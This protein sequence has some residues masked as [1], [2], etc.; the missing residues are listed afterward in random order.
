VVRQLTNSDGYSATDG[1]AL[2][3]E[4]LR[5]A[6]ANG[7]DIWLGAEIV[8][9]ICDE[10]GIHGV[11]VRKDDTGITVTAR[12]AVLLATGGFAGSQELREEYLPLPTDVSWSLMGQ[13]SGKLLNMA[14]NAGAKTSAMND[15]WWT[16]VTLIGGRVY[17]LDVA[18]T[19]PHSV[20]V[21]QAGDRFFD[22]AAPPA[23][24]VR[25]LFARG[26]GVRTVP[27]YLIM[28][29]RH[30]KSVAIG[31]WEAGIIPTDSEEG[32]IISAKTLNDLAVELNIDRAGLIG[33]IVRFNGFAHK[34]EDLDFHRG[35]SIWS[36]HALTGKHGK[37]IASLGKLDKKPFWAVKVYPGDE[38]TKGGLLVNEHSQVLR[39]DNSW[40]SGLYACG[41]AAASIMKGTSPG[42]GAA[43]SEALIQAYLAV[44]DMERKTKYI[45]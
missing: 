42:P 39:E 17:P 1:E 22:E 24:V 21:N 35:E 27:S 5:R 11:E 29:N 16:P 37:R 30:R 10:S 36:R 31:P 12:I 8:S 20:I 13:N 25:A 18:R 15:A 7:V 14:I 19:A 3:A 28:D 33:T 2:A 43:L 38:G 9:L 44:I 41:G 45:P 6:T 34:G 40:I 26:L 32:D 4:L 23:E